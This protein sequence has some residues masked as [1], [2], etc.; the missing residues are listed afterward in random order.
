MTSKQICRCLAYGKWNPR[1]HVIVPNCTFAGHEAD[2]L[3]MTSAGYLTEVEI[4]VSVADF[5]RDF[6]T[7]A[8]KHRSMELGEPKLKR[9]GFDPDN[10][11]HWR[12]RGHTAF[13]D[14]TEPQPRLIKHFYFAVPEDIAEKVQ[15]LVPA[16]AGLV[17]V[18]PHPYSGFRAHTVKAAPL[19]TK[20]RP[21]TDKEKVALMRLAYLRF[22]DVEAKEQ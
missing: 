14:Y 3:V 21:L 7:K 22:W 13:W 5:R 12:P 17:V 8:W 19:L 1:Q 20:A 16:Y 2:M 15:P 9:S 10:P 18:K 4:K 11:R 6:V